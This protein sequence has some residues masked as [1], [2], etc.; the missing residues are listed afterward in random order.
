MKKQR[1]FKLLSQT[2]FIYLVFTFIAFF[3][4]V[5]FLTHEADQFINNALDHRFRKAERYI[6]DRIGKGF[7]FENHATIFVKP[8]PSEP[9]STR[10]PQYT[11][12]LIYNSNQDEMQQYRKKTALIRV[13]DRCYRAEIIKPLDDFYRLR[14]DIFGALIPA[15][16]FLALGIVL[17]N[18]LLSGYFF[19]PLNKILGIMRTYR[20]GQGLK[21]PTVKTRTSEFI[22]LQDLFHQM[23]ARIENEYRNLKEYTE[24][25][26]HEM[27]TPLSVIRNKTE[28]LIASEGV[29]KQ[30]AA[31]VKIIYDETNHLSK[32]GNTLNLMTKIENGEFS[33]SI[34]VPTQPVIGQLVDATQELARL[35]LMKIETTLS[36]EHRLLIDPFLLDL[37]LKNLLRN[38]I[39]YGTADGPIRITTTPEILTI[40]NYG[41]PLQVPVD[42]LFER[43]YRSGNRQTA[44]GLGLSL[45]KKICELNQLTIDYQYRENQHGFCVGRQA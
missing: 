36:A 1:N 15:F 18:Y 9:D 17:F 10:F 23:I 44:L 37:M 40:T 34:E 2:T 31:T 33:N 8:V 28:N 20:V 41:P 7:F 24:N 4:S 29:M 13:G 39:R 5:V 27:Q 35:K 6:A 43:F 26:A 3:S 30:Q 21:I 16:V 38:A 22:K 32:L 11:D 45:V 12:T 14:D 42:K 25:M 19:Q